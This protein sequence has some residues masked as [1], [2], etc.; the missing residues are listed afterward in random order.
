MSTLTVPTWLRA[1]QIG[2]GIVITVLSII[3]I[4]NPVIGFLSLIWLLGILLFV[5]GIEMIVSHIFT[6]H[7]SRFA[8]IG[9]GIAVIILAIIAIAFPLITSII[10]IALLGVALLFSGISKIIH[11]IDDKQSKSWKRGFG[12]AVGVFS[13]ILAIMILVFP[14]FGIAFAGLL[15]GIS[16]LVTGVQMIAIGATGRIEN[17]NKNT[18]DF[19]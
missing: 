9:L 1:F 10:I 4:I 13:V 2:L 19:R 16:L 14:V 15:I 12:I 18:N 7:K 17:N 8:G 11:G 3:V 5:V 6:P